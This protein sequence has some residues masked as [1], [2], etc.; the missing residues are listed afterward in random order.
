MHYPFTVVDTQT[1]DVYEQA[2][3]ITVTGKYTFS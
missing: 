3:D 1:Q 2:T